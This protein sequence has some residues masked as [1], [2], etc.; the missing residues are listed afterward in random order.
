MYIIIVCDV[1]EISGSCI[2]WKY[3]KVYQCM[4]PCD[5]SGEEDLVI[6]S[7]VNFEYILDAVLSRI[8]LYT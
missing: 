1:K 6:T 7:C 2:L 4:S 5:G 3:K 8:L